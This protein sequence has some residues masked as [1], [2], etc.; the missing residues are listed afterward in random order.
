MAGPT[1]QNLRMHNIADSLS[2]ALL[3][4][5]VVLSPWAFGTTQPPVIWMMNGAGYF[6]GALLFIKI[7]IRWRTGYRPTRWS[8][9]D[10]SHTVALRWLLALSFSV[11]AFCLVSAL[12][13]RSTYL[14][15]QLS[16]QYHNF[17]GWLP[18]SYDAPG[19]WFRFW[20][21]LGLAIFFWAARDWLLGKTEMEQRAERS[22]EIERG[23]FSPLPGRLHG[24]LWL[25]SINGALLALEGIVQR[26]SG[27]NKLLWF[28]PTRINAAAEFQFGPFA[29]RGNAASYLNLVW[30][31]CLALW[32]A[33]R[34]GSRF[35]VPGSKLHHGLLICVALMAAAAI[36]SASRGGAVVCIG[37]IIVAA[38]L[39]LLALKRGQGLTK[40]VIFFLFA[41]ALAGGFA[42]G[43][44]KLGERMR[45]VGAGFK[46]REAIYAAAKPMAEEHPLFGT[47][48]GTFGALFQF[49]RPSPETYWPA[50]L[51]N[52]WLE[53]RITF[54]WLGSGLIAAAFALVVA[55]WFLPG[56]IRAG[57]RFVLLIWL[58]MAGCLVH[59]RYDFPFQIHS[60]VLLFVMLCAVMSTLSRRA[61][62]I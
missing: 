46:S 24:L 26:L 10:A 59:A 55:R 57:K 12:N 42:F 15:G 61:K 35:Q 45:D 16:F 4:A 60:I 56:G 47:G 7:F 20:Q 11:P 33:L 62:V 9:A 37:E 2:G 52:D 30:P 51:H 36:V 18:H 41:G 21:Y 14:P 39:L 1:L 40:L 27:T 29:Y 13:A 28:E 48:P 8:A 22:K 19:T 25:L 54:G 38:V 17:V 6:L 31:V 3:F 32:W 58:A 23:N 34:R 50:Q 5:M 49:Y 53:T 43:W 44:D